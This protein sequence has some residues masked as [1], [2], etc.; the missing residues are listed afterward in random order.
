M[1]QMGADSD[2]IREL[3]ARE[4][5]RD[6]ICSY[7]RA[8]DNSDAERLEKL[9]HPEGLVDSGVIRAKP[10]EFAAQFVMWLQ[11]NT[12]SVFHAICGTQFE[13]SGERAT[14]DVQVLALCQMKPWLGGARVITAGRYSDEYVMH[15]GKW[16][17]RE[18]I[19][20]P[21]LSWNFPPAN[22]ADVD[23]K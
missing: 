18:R 1:F 6:L 17:I 20:K 10:K 12:V 9:F 11:Q 2:I 23:R 3:Y 21:E 13:V 22:E 19:F 4:A 7:C 5:L 14:G 15:G 16:L 8:A